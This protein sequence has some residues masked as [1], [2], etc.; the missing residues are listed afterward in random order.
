MERLDQ[1]SFFVAELE[2]NGFVAMRAVQKRL[3]FAVRRKGWSMHRSAAT[4]LRFSGNTIQN[5][6]RVLELLAESG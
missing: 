5:S 4:E 1:L 2:A 3:H 6:N